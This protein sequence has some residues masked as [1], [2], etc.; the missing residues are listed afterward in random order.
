MITQLNT[1]KNMK[2]IKQKELKNA[3]QHATKENNNQ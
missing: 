2:T 1:L 3:V